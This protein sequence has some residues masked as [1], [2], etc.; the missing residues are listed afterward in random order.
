MWRR[1]LSLA[2]ALSAAAAWSAAAQQGA[3]PSR[4][5]AGLLYAP[6]MVQQR[7]P[8]TPRDNDSLVRA[9]EGRIRCTCGCNL[10]VFTCRTT[11][12]TCA[13]SP[14]MHRQVLAM[15]DSSRTPEQ[16]Y[17]AFEARYGQAIFMAP[18]RR[19]FNWTAYLMPFVGLLLG[20]GML[21]A[22]MRRW[23]TARSAPRAAPTITEAPAG[24]SQEELER[25]K[26]ELERF[27]A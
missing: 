5:T 12:F 7:E 1:S 3:P 10:D 24:V 14:A 17:A 21:G 4:D 8:T 15:L 26:R 9:I 22:V 20:L 16:I 6:R 13:T 19:G 2:V 23:V 11:D 25:L 18:P 27:E